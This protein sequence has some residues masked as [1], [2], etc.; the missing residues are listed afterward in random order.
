MAWYDMISY[1]MI[2]HRRRLA[3]RGVAWS[4][5]PTRWRTPQ[6]FCSERSRSRGPNLVN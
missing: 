1:D 6:A 4:L 2:T 5:R 3:A